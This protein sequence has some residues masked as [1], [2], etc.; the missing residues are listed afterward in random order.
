[1]RGRRKVA[2]LISSGYDL[3]PY[4]AGRASTDRVQGGRFADPTRFLLERDNPYQRLPAVTADIDLLAYLRELTLTANRANVTLYP[5]DP[6]GLTGVVDAGKYLDQSDWRTVV[7]KSQSSLRYLA[8]QTGGRAVVNV[9][10]F[11]SEFRRID[12]ETSD[13]YL[14]GYTSTNADASK[15]VRN[16]EARVNRP[17]VVVTSRSAYSV[18]PGSEPALK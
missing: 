1:M 11:A 14:V 3:D 8:E 9:N 10:D 18:G 12:A 15:R 4:A 16:V 13:Y 2:L 7:Q 6:R 17:G 5:V